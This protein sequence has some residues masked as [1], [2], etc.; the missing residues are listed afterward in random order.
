MIGT[1]ACPECG[2]ELESGTLA[3][4]QVRCMGCAALVEVPFLPRSARRGRRR[5]PKDWAWGLIGFSLVLAAL[6][7]L[8]HGVRS[9]IR[10][11]G[12]ATV[13][14]LANEADEAE[15][16]GR[17]ADAL[18]ALDEARAQVRRLGAGAPIGLDEL[19]ARREGVRARGR[20]ELVRR[21][22]A[23]LE[24]ARRALRDGLD[25]E[26][27]ALTER[28]ASRATRL[29]ADAAAPINAAARAV[30][31]PILAARGVVL[32]PFQGR[33]LPDS[34]GPKRLAGALG[35]SLTSGLK[36]AG[37]LPKPDDSPLAGLW[38]ECAGYR[39]EVEINERRLGTYNR[40]K[41]RLSHI[42]AH[43]VLNRSDRTVWQVWVAGR[44]RVPCPDVSAYEAVQLGL[45]GRRDPELER[46]LYEDALRT[47]AARMPE[48]LRDL[49]GP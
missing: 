21:A 20:V 43:V 15:R 40:S 17:F 3:G 46:R 8:I 1:F 48:P 25:A 42:A 24:G 5:P 28:A 4:R 45:P 29:R 33:F 11:A 26:A 44:T 9:K 10:Q 18:A 19:E 34:G 41:N 47:L 12:V 7:L 22:E 2:A 13:R 32:A 39:L 14:R 38:D 35:P 27:I 6:G 16:D 31:S 37:Y 49:P 23:D 30:A 36:A